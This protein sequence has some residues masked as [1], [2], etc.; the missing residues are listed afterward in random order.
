VLRNSQTALKWVRP[1]GVILC[2]IA[3]Y[4]LMTLVPIGLPFAYAILLWV[5]LALLSF[6]LLV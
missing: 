1:L 5:V 4:F 6:A 2:S 3:A